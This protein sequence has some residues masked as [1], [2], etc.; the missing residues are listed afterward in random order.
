M[1]ENTGIKHFLEDISEY[2]LR[3]DTSTLSGGLGVITRT[4]DQVTENVYREATAM[5]RVDEAGSFLLQPIRSIDFA[6]YKPAFLAAYLDPKKK[7]GIKP[8]KLLFNTPETLKATG[9]VAEAEVVGELIMKARKQI[10]DGAGSIYLAYK[11]LFLAKG[12]IGKL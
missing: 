3:K 10:V 7:M 2:K 8:D 4:A 5:S 9:H 1:L 11:S 12:Q 6:L